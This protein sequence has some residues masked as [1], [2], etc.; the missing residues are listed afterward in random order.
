[1]IEV[2][3]QKEIAQRTAEAMRGALR[4]GVLPGGG[5]A[6]IAC[7]SLLERKLHQ[8]QEPDERAAYSILLHAC[9]APLRTLLLNAGHDPN[10]V[11]ASVYRAGAGYG[12]DVLRRQVVDM[13]QVGI[14]D[15]ASVVRAAVFS[16]IHGAALALTVDVM[17][18]RKNPPDASATP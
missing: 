3:R 15:A 4:E 9:E 10:E 11:L 17:V 16:A 2:E 18:H 14:F 13:S 12:F 1:V 6:L 8:A 5:A 7:R